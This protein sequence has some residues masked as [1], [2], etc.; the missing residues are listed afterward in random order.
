MTNEEALRLIR[1]SGHP[2]CL[3]VWSLAGNEIVAVGEAEGP[4]GEEDGLCVG[5][6]VDVATV[7]LETL[8]A[9]SER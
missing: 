5:R 4:L 1:S 9:Q 6:F 3:L 8:R 7:S 2:V